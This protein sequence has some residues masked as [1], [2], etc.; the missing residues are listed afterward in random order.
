MALPTRDELLTSVDTA[1]RQRVPRAPA[2]LDP[3]DESHAEMIDIWWETYHAVL[4]KMTDEAFF[5]FFPAAPDQLDP[6]DSNQ[7]LLVE[8]WKD[9]AAQISGEAGHHNW[10]NATVANDSEEI[11][12]PAQ[13]GSAHLQDRIG[14][15]LI[16]MEEYAKAVGATALG[17]KV[18]THTMA[19]IDKL[20]E[21]VREG[22]FQH[23]DHWWRSES[24]AETLYDDGGSNE[25]IA[26][27]R[28]LTLE[29]KI[30]RTDGTLDI[31]LSGWAT[32]FRH[33]GSFGRVSAV[34]T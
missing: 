9:I 26:F 14:Y 2:K 23:Y 20:R 21:L 12:M 29:A 3:N 19:Q 31:R 24:F 34:N 28:D 7:A 8:Y 11:E 15:V 18:I 27:V 17:P 16:L 5:T 30:D 22:T 33:G 25:E 4:S 6:N 32:D 10:S 13:D 1:F